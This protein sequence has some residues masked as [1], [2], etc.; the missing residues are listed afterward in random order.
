MILR[1]SCSFGHRR[2]DS[3]A[4]AFGKRARERRTVT[5]GVQ[6][7]RSPAVARVCRL[8]GVGSPAPMRQ[9]SREQDRLPPAVQASPGSVAVDDADH[10]GGAGPS[11]EVRGDSSGI[12]GN[13][14]LLGSVR[15]DAQAARSRRRLTAEPRCAAHGLGTMSVQI[16]QRIDAQRVGRRP[17][18]IVR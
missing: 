6:L 7:E 12:F 4:V 17:F 2:H 5:V 11:L 3:V 8:R 18:T 1:A 15:Q 10:I 16:R 14:R 9:S 13:E